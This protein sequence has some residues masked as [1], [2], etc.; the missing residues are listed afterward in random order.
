[1]N[2]ECKKTIHWTTNVALTTLFM[3]IAAV[4]LLVR[5]TTVFSAG[6]N[7]PSKMILAGRCPCWLPRLD[8]H[9]EQRTHLAR[10]P[11]TGA[12][13]TLYPR[14]AVRYQ[15]ERWVSRGSG[16]AGI[17]LV[18]AKIISIHWRGK[19]INAGHRRRATAGG[20]RAATQPARRPTGA[21]IT[22]MSLVSA[23]G[24]T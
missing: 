9:A 23:T 2:F 11:R 10:Q 17:R 14:P 12:R 13:Q 1:M 22:R 20:R 8:G 15:P 19:Y 6:F 3:M 5:K 18:G 24:T 7:D 4:P 21:P 16:P